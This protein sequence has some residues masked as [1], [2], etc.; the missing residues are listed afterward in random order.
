MCSCS[1]SSH[2][3]AIRVAIGVAIGHPIGVAIRVAMPPASF[4]AHSTACAGPVGTLLRGHPFALQTGVHE[5]FRRDLEPGAKH[6]PIRL[7]QVAPGEPS[8]RLPVIRQGVVR[9]RKQEHLRVGPSL[10]RR[11]RSRADKEVGRVHREPLGNS[12][13]KPFRPGRDGGAAWRC[14]PIPAPIWNVE[15]A[16]KPLCGS[17]APP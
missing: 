15:R 7:R 13:L 16:A 2:R 3:F 6:R 14:N 4:R 11:H 8:A 10:R 17:P 5:P 1:C 12:H 9:P